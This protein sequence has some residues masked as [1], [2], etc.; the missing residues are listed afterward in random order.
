LG[1][2]VVAMVGGTPKRVICLTC[3]SQHNYRAPRSAV[4]K[5][6]PAAKRASAASRR[7][8][9][10]ESWSGRCGGQPLS[11]FTP[12]A[13]DRSFAT[14]ELVTHARFGT[15][16]VRE[17]RQDSKVIIVFQDAVRTLAHRQG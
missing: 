10:A 7:E 8:P 14:G 1:H 17:V 13:M 2:R 15:G 3:G 16:F 12:Y 9:S 5:K 4:V 6:A 11:A